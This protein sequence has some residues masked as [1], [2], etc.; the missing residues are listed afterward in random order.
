MELRVFAS[1]G[2]CHSAPPFLARTKTL[3]IKHSQRSSS[4]RVGLRPAHLAQ[5]VK[6]LPGRIAGIGH[7]RFDT[8]EIGLANHNYRALL[9]NIQRTPLMT[10][11]PSLQA[12][13]SPTA[14]H[15][16]SCTCGAMINHCS[17]IN[18]SRRA[19]S[20]A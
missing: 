2:P 3:L 18:P 15:D 10:S 1:L 7:G 6:R 4:P 11:H 5:L 16:D 19:I 17:S 12:L 13:L 9:L 14:H 20:L 8:E